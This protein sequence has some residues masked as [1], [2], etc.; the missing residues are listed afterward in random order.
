[1]A[2]NFAIIVRRGENAEA[3]RIDWNEPSAPVQK[4]DVVGYMRGTAFDGTQ[5][6]VAILAGEDVPVA[7]KWPLFVGI[8][9][10]GGVFLRQRIKPRGRA[11]R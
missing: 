8:G 10:V 1:M 7:A 6:Q 4:G 3:P 2:D 5:M 9:A 11:K